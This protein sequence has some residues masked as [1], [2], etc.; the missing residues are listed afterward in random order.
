LLRSDLSLLNLT[1]QCQHL[2]KGRIKTIL[3][4]HL[5]KGG[6]IKIED[7]VILLKLQFILDLIIL[8]VC[9]LLL[10][11]IHITNM[12]LEL[13]GGKIFIINSAHT[14]GYFG[15]GQFTSCLG[16]IYTPTN[17][18]NFVINDAHSSCVV[19]PVKII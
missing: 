8:Q 6:I 11:C 9:P 7:L 16:H 4:M 3:C 14:G 1:L 17:G 19:I 2:K 5:K 13:C 10:R 12:R 15:F 18:F